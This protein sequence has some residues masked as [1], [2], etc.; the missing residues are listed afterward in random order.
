MFCSASSGQQAL[1]KLQSAFDVIQ[2]R[3][4][5]LKLVLNVDKTKYMLFSGSQKFDKNV[6]SLQTLQGTVIE[7]VKEYKYLAIIVDDALSFSSHITQLKNFFKIK[8]GFYFR[9]KFVFH[10]MYERNW[11][12][13]LFYPCLTM[14]YQFA[15]SYLLSSLDAVY[16]GALRFISDCKP[17]SLG[18]AGAK[19]VS[20]G[21]I[22]PSSP[23]M[24]T[25]P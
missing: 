19:Q 14:V 16:H 17:S 6:S 11:L 21:A 25:L 13:L 23:H 12:P 8:L 15:P 1:Y 22:S 20:D 18:C 2:S 9:N 24:H 10:S 7:S 5:N 3:I 4:Y